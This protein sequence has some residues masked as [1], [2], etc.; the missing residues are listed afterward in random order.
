MKSLEKN[1]NKL[2]NYLPSLGPLLIKKDILGAVCF[3]TFVS[4]NS[5][6]GVDVLSWQT[7]ENR[8]RKPICIEESVYPLDKLK[9]QKLANDKE[10]QIKSKYGVNTI[11]RVIYL[12]SALNLDLLEDFRIL[13]VLRAAEY[14]R[15][16]SSPQ[17]FTSSITKY[18]K[19]AYDFCS[20]LIHKH[21]STRCHDFLL[22]TIKPSDFVD[23]V[24]RHFN[25][26]QGSAIY[27]LDMQ[28]HCR[29]LTQPDPNCGQLAQ[30]YFIKNHLESCLAGHLEPPEKVIIPSETISAGSQPASLPEDENKPSEVNKTEPLDPSTTINKGSQ[31]KSN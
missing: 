8:W 23:L 31:N 29:N 17:T 4:G 6:A 27:S 22:V 14:A 2:K 28:N 9:A 11:E 30:E 10:N 1:Y 21:P 12:S 5:F 19:L 26:Y 3:L 24:G 15:S 18:S 7:L 16:S 13:M 20:R 25:E